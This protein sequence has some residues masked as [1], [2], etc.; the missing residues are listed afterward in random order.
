M[1]STTNPV[2]FFNESTEF[3]RDANFTIE[4]L[5]GLYR[6]HYSLATD[7]PGGINEPAYLRQLD[8]W[9]EWWRAQ[10]EVVHVNTLSDTM[11]RLNKN[12][13]GDDPDAYVLPDN[14]ELA[15]QYLLL[16]EMS[17]PYGLDLNNQVNIDKSATRIVI[18]VQPI[19]MSEILELAER[20]E[21]WLAENGP[22]VQGHH[23][24]GMIMM[25]S[26][27]TLTNTFS[28]LFGTGVA[29]VLIG[30]V[31]M[32]ALRS[33]Q[34]RPSEP[35]PQSCTHCGRFRAMGYF[36]WKRRHRVVDCW[37]HDVGHRGR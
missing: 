26:H 4:N 37:Q 35:D 36:Q 15:A 13:H 16:Y 19:K 25:F 33:F 21:S 32:L 31:L 10:P 8:A 34:T 12:M 9:A 14:R 7:S 27:L 2:E 6:I 1:R 17:L 11:R 28:M 18:T 20:G 30:G 5:T 24:A 22:D 29:I 3:R 23:G